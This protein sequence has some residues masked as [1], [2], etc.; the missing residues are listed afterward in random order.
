MKTVVS[1]KTKPLASVIKGCYAFL[2]SLN[3]DHFK[4]SL[5]PALQKAMLRNPEVILEAVG[6]IISGLNLDL[7]QYALD[8]GNSLIGNIC[9]K[10]IRKL[11][12]LLF[13]Q[14]IYIPK[15]I[16]QEKKLRM[17]VRD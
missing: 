15:M 1:S 16:W 10:I 2:K 13:L 7:S 9:F 12:Y 6:L 4:N 5:Q 8:L 3:H 17:D 11:S 14:L